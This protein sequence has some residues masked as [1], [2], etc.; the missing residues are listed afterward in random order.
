M[1]LADQLKQEVFGEEDKKLQNF[2]LVV[3]SGAEF[4]LLKQEQWEAAQLKQEVLG[5]EALTP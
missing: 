1:L 3:Q 4:L 5:E 2:L